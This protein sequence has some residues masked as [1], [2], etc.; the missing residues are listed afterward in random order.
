MDQFNRFLKWETVDIQL[1]FAQ[2]I[3]NHMTLSAQM[4]LRYE[5]L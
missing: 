1:L 5:I 2:I 3:K 4:I